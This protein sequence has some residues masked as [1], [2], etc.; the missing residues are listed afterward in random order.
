[1][2]NYLILVD[3]TPY[4]KVT[5]KDYEHALSYVNSKYSFE[6]LSKYIVIT[7]VK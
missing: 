7:E 6:G 1:M 2:R 4:I 5:A 3:S